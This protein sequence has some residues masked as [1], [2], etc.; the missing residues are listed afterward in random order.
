MLYAIQY[1]LK[2]LRFPLHSL[3]GPSL[4]SSSTSEYL[5]SDVA[6]TSCRP[7]STS[8]A[9]FLLVE[10]TGGSVIDP[11]GG[12]IGDVKVVM[13]AVGVV[14]GDEEALIG[15]VAVVIEDVGGM[16][17]E[18]GDGIDDDD[19]EIDGVD[20]DVGGGML[21]DVDVEIDDVGGVIETEAS[22]LDKLE[23][24]LSKVLSLSFSIDVCSISSSILLPSATNITSS[25]PDEG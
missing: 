24:A 21:E 10:D 17:W 4:Q 23:S 11:V 15:D 19:G 6:S 3:F 18:V 25:T 2:A 1:S 9:S 16:I 5:A 20:D 12:V 22:P 8:A 7:C 13:G 14:I